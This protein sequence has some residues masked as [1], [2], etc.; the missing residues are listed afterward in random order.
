MQLNKVCSLEDILSTYRSIDGSC[1]HQTDGSRGVSFTGYKR[2]LH[3][4][5]LDGVQEPRR[6]VT[7][8]ILPSPRLISTSLITA[9]NSDHNQLTL[10]VMLWSE[11][12]EHDVSHTATSKM[13]ELTF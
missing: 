4:E 7:K 1:N 8:K 2:L 5:Y 9:S 3:P 13:S 12:V 10:A 11:F 6:S